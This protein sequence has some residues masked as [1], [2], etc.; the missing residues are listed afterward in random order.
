MINDVNEIKNDIDM[1]EIKIGKAA[2]I[3][4][5]GAALLSAI[6]L[7][8][9][10]VVAEQ[11]GYSVTQMLDQTFEISVACVIVLFVSAI[12]IIRNILNLKTGIEVGEGKLTVR[13]LKGLFLKRVQLENQSI[14]R[15]YSEQKLTE[16]LFRLGTLK[17]QPMGKKAIGIRFAV[18]PWEYAEWLSDKI[19]EKSAKGQVLYE[20]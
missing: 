2:L 6:V 11:Y 3:C 12:G 19:E 5:I 7:I 20:R 18:K 8:A 10:C 17:I 4:Y 13:Y 1:K 16:K 15:V 9:F 14:A